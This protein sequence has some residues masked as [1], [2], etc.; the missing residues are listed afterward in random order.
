MQSDFIFTVNH[1]NNDPGLV[2]PALWK[3]LDVVIGQLK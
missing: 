1:P 2:I 3:K